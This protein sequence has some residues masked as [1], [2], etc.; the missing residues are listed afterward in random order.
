M[1]KILSLTEKSHNFFRTF[2]GRTLFYS[3]HLSFFI[4]LQKVESIIE[5]SLDKKGAIMGA[6]IHTC[7]WEFLNKLNSLL[8][9]VSYL[10]HHIFYFIIYMW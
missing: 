4:V 2:N 9:I 3:D 10:Y 5:V 7:D 8:L 1:T 6:N